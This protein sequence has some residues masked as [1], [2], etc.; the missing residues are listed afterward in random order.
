MTRRAFRFAAIGLALTAAACGQAAPPDTSAADMTAITAVRNEFIAAFNAGDAARAANGYAPNGMSFSN[1]QPT[2]NGRDAILANMKGQF[3]AMTAKIELMPDETKLFG[4]WALDRGRFKISLTPKAAGAPPINDEGRYV[5]LLQRQADKSW[6]V[7][8][9][10]DNSILPM[11]EPP[12]K[13][14]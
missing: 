2:Q 14:K 4:D 3:E 1:H 5:V 9:D 10:M 6:K 11:P 13:E 7:V 12:K 8:F